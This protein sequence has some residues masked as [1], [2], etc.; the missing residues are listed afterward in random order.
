MTGLKVLQYNIQSLYKNKTNLKFLIDLIKQK[1]KILNYNIV[2]TTRDDIYGG[3]TI[4]F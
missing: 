2:E 3:V 1:S 4:G